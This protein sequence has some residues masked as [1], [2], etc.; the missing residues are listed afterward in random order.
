MKQKPYG[1]EN[2]E[3]WKTCFR[4]LVKRPEI[5]QRSLLSFNCGCV[6]FGAKNAFRAYA[7]HGATRYTTDVLVPP[8]WSLHKCLL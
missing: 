7:V 5:Q 3:E 8:L 4:W 1:E 2:L 6:S